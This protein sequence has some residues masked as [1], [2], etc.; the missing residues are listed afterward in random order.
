MGKMMIERNRLLELIQL[1]ELGEWAS[2]LEAAKQLAD[3]SMRDSIR[4]AQ[5]RNYELYMQGRQ[6][7][8]QY[9]DLKDKLRKL[10]KEL[11]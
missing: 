1:M 9:K 11:L 6:S 4:A 7:E 5:R 8:R 10:A 2:A 3:T